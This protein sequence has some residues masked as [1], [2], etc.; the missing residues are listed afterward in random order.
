MTPSL[1]SFGILHHPKKPD[2]LVLADR[3]GEFARDHGCTVWVGNAWDEP[4]TLANIAGL[5]VL[6]TLGGDGT[7]LRAARIASRYGVPILGVKLGRVSFLG[8]ISPEDWQEPISRLLQGHYW[9]EERMLL[10]VAVTHQGEPGEN[11]SYL[12]LNRGSR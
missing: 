10:D 8:E 12:A 9:V 4:E 2:S 6:I 3:I 11:H 1:K 7:I 5:D